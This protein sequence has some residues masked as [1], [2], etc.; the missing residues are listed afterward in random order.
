MKFVGGLVIATI[1]AMVAGCSSP[2]VSRSTDGLLILDGD[3]PTT[4][5]LVLGHGT[6]KAEGHCLILTFKGLGEFQPV[7]PKGSTRAE[8]ENRL[9]SLTVPRDVAVGGFDQYG[10]ELEGADKTNEV[11]ECRGKPGTMSGF[12]LWADE[13]FPPMPSDLGQS[14]VL[15]K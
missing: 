11:K 4:F 8:L 5:N 10:S 15:R 13:I 1:L 9:G 7:F 2:T 3:Y 6:L 12:N 14:S